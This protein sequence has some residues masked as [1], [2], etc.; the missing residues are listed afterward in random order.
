MRSAAKPTGR[1]RFNIQARRCLVHPPSPEA[2]SAAAA[3]AG[4]PRRSVPGAHPYSHPV[5]LPLHDTSPLRLRGLPR[6]RHW[7]RRGERAPL[8]ACVRWARGVA[9]AGSTGRSWRLMAVGASAG[10]TRA[11][12][13]ATRI[14]GGCIIDK[15][16]ADH[17]ADVPLVP[18]EGAP[19][20]PTAVVSPWPCERGAAIVHHP[21]AQRRRRGGRAQRRT[22]TPFALPPSL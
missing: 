8:A 22:F 5:P 12:K 2:C 6:A 16:M 15:A 14:P 4:A 18:L 11:S 19:W 10:Q 13:K 20:A 1:D 21:G 3:G 9:A 17:V 7:R